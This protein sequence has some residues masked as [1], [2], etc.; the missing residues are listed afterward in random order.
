MKI[1]G[2]RLTLRSI[3][4]LSRWRSLSYEIIGLQPSLNPKFSESLNLHLGRKLYSLL[5]TDYWLLITIY[6]LLITDYWLLITIYWLLKLHLSEVPCARVRFVVSPHIALR[7]CGV[8]KIA[9]LRGAGFALSK[10]Q[11]LGISKSP[12]RAKAIQFTDYSFV[13]A[14]RT[15]PWEKSV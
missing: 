1:L 9:P 10:S 12:F 2:Y 4:L 5:I 14:Y 7:L 11:I 3:K 15:P 13:F 8:T 6:W